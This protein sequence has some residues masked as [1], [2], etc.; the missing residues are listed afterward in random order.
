LKTSKETGFARPD[1]STS[2]SSAASQVI[3]A[4]AGTTHSAAFFDP[5]N[6]ESVEIR[7]QA[8]ME[9]L[10]ELLIWLQNG[11][12]VAIHDA[13][14][15]TIKR[16][17]QLLK[18]VSQ[19]KN[20]ECFF[21]ESICSDQDL[22]EKNIQLKLQGPDYLRMDPVAAIADFKQRIKNYERAYQTI[23]EEEEAAGLSYI[24]L[25]NVGQ[26]MISNRIHGYLPSQ[27]AFYLMQLNINHRIFSLV[28]YT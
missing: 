6:T 24:K 7:N 26:K 18:R 13:T 20:V 1:S 5:L 23:S 25:I 27:A 19:Y 22:L 8:A 14:N 16:R 2:I 15:S 28:I 12:K 4:E 10:D 17:Q 21:I 3:P 9:T 11:G